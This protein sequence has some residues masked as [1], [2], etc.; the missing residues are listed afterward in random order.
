MP[1]ENAFEVI[2]GVL[3]QDLTAGAGDLSLQQQ[4]H[5]RA[6]RLEDAE[7]AGEGI[8]AAIGRVRALRNLFG[9][10]EQGFSQAGIGLPPVTMLDRI[11]GLDSEPSTDPQTTP[12]VSPHPSEVVNG[13]FTLTHGMTISGLTDR[14]GRV[15]SVF[16]KNPDSDYTGTYVAEQVWPQFSPE[17]GKNNFGS[18]RAFLNPKLADKLH[19]IKNVSGRERGV[20]GRYKLVYL[21]N[22][23]GDDGLDSGSISETSDLTELSSQPAPDGQNPAPVTTPVLAFRDAPPPVVV[24]TLSR[25]D[26]IRK[27]I[28]KEITAVCLTH[29]AVRGGLDIS[30]NPLDLLAPFIPDDTSIRAV[31]GVD[32]QRPDATQRIIDFIAEGIKQ[33]V[34]EAESKELARYTVVDGR[35]INALNRIESRGKA[36][37]VTELLISLYRHFRLQVPEEYRSVSAQGRRNG[38]RS[39][40][41]LLNRDGFL[42]RPPSLSDITVWVERQKELRV[43]K[44]YQSQSPAEQVAWELLNDFDSYSLLE[45]PSILVLNK[46]A[47]IPS[48]FGSRVPI[49]VVEIAMYLRGP[50]T[51]LA[52]R[53]D[54]D[55]TGVLVLAKS[56][57]ALFGLSNQ[58]ANKTEVGMRKIYWAL[59]DGEFTDEEPR[60]VDVPI[61]S[62]E[63]ERMT[64]ITKEQDIQNAADARQSLSIFRPLA[65]L[66]SPF[67]AHQTLT[68]VQIITGRTHQIRVVAADYLHHPVVGDRLY[69]PEYSKSSRMML[70]ALELTFQHPIR[71]NRMNVQAPLP[72]EFLTGLQTMEWMYVIHKEEVER[73]LAPRAA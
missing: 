73:I 69:D 20:E 60:E 37:N 67:G 19:S 30:T 21:G 29:L 54:R 43:A 33:S 62:T 35:I 12:K 70:H 41:P 47:G 49:G 28:Q 22:E 13:V 38:H 58:F 71:G 52:H 42:L 6:G 53:L 59:L 50:Q 55:T 66:R 3:E 8:K 65:L 39:S 46:P 25:M 16:L 5:L 68:E 26:E 51:R 72:R 24:E 48:H 2:F 56:D 63:T 32:E 23:G 57:T 61:A 40:N 15:L 17:A 10:L 31:I 11:L 4:E 64:V 1:K 18:T 7:A 27:T 45:D 34:T 44:R 9:V 14:E 36:F